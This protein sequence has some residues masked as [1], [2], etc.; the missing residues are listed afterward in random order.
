MQYNA[1]V[2]AQKYI[3][4]SIYTLFREISQY[5]RKIKSHHWKPD[6]NSPARLYVISFDPS[7]TKIFQR[8]DATFALDL[9][10]NPI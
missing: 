5:I 1:H 9:M 6:D 3:D 7:A 4:S 10:I 2:I 8:N